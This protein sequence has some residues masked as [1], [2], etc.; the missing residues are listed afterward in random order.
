MG[1]RAAMHFAS[2][3][4]SL[5]SP[6][7]SRRFTLFI[8]VLM[9]MITGQEENYSKLAADARS[10]ITYAVIVALSKNT[11]CELAIYGDHYQ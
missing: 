6:I 9:L 11:L 4:P 8:R 10:I 5:L 7:D 3:F 1:M 2:G